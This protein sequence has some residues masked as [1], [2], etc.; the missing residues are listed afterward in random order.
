MC[1]IAALVNPVKSD[2]IAEA[3]FSQLAARL[4]PGN[5][6]DTT[7]FRPASRGELNGY[8]RDSWRTNATSVC[9]S[10]R[11]AQDP[12]EKAAGI[13]PRLDRGDCDHAV[14]K[15]GALNEVLRRQSDR[16]ELP[17][18]RHKL[19]SNRQHDLQEPLSWQRCPLC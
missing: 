17:S 11:A 3:L 7:H 9:L 4:S 1:Q 13:R 18:A 10:C 19:T 12:A 8:D 6:T 15:I 16:N 14:G 2:V 5:S